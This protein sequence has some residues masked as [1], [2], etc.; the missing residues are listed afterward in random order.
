VKDA[1]KGVRM[2]ESLRE[3]IYREAGT[4]AQNRLSLLRYLAPSILVAGGYDFNELRQLENADIG[5]EYVSDN[6][7]EDPIVDPL[8]CIT[9]RPFNPHGYNTAPYELV[10]LLAGHMR[11][12]LVGAE[13]A[14][15]FDGIIKFAYIKP[16]SMGRWKDAAKHWR[17]SRA[18]EMP[19]TTNTP[20]AVQR[21]AERW[22]AC[23]DAGLDMP[24]DTY[25]HYPRGISKVAKSFGIERQSLKEDLDKYREREFGN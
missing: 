12:V 6:W 24:S 18:N 4:D 23:V 22:K 10:W 9:I 8:P 13:P 15:N 19:R 11:D 3:F 17:T 16:E 20:M 5:C 7:D 1:Q 25:S 21:Q 2:R 14:P